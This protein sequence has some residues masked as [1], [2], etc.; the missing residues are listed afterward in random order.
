MQ[1]RHR[2]IKESD[3]THIRPS[4]ILERKDNYVLVTTW[5]GGSGGTGLGWWYLS[6]AGRYETTKE[7]YPENNLA[8]CLTSK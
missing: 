7:G 8:H 2:R 1:I 6:L 3:T 4:T 5:R